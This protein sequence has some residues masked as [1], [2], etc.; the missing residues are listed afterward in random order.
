[1]RDLQRRLAAIEKRLAP[2]HGEAQVIEVRGGLHD[3]PHFASAGELRWQRVPNE[4]Y[5]S[6]RSRVVGEARA[7]VE[8]FIVI[9]GL[10]SR[11]QLG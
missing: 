2:H 6:F 11:K 7:A 9:G 5:A 10:P 3:D 4:S 1:M 8:P